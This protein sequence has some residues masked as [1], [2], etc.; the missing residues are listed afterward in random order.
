MT[1][2][3]PLKRKHLYYATMWVCVHW[4]RHDKHGNVI[5]GHGG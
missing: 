1:Y 5:A 4:W 3:P 2:F